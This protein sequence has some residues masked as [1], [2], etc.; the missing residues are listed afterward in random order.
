LRRTMA[1]S[2]D[3]D[4]TANRI[5]LAL[6]ANVFGRVRSEMELVELPNQKVIYKVEDPINHLYFVERGLISLIKTMRDGRT[7]EIGVIGI[8]G[9]PAR[10]PSSA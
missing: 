7:V 4:V 2:R 1:L 10:T 6:P 5:L 3:N 8:E 9:M